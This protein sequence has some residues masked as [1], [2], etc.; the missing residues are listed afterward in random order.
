MC[1]P[2]GGDNVSKTVSGIQLRMFPC[3]SA[4]GKAASSRWRRLLYWLRSLWCGRCRALVAHSEAS[5]EELL[6][7]GLDSR[8]KSAFDLL[9]GAESV[10]DTVLDLFEALEAG[11]SAQQR[12]GEGSSLDDF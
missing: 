7:R 2:V 3:E 8:L 6:M 1:R 10:L 11:F 4:E 9:E 12:S 5:R